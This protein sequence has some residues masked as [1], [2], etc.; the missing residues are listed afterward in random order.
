MK[1][2]KVQFRIG[3]LAKQLNVEKFVIRFWEKEFSLSST[4]SGGG[5]RFY[6]QE[7][8]DN[9][10]VIKSLLYDQGFTIAGAK[11]LLSTNPKKI[12]GSYKTHMNTHQGN[13]QQQ[14]TTVVEKYTALREQLVALRDL[15]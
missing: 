14:T 4:R 3:E 2:Q 7:D 13:T 9:F 12:V 1:I 10:Q 15:L 5:Q 6:T 8:L 11:K